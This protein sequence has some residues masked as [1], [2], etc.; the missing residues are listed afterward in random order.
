MDAHEEF[1]IADPHSLAK[2]CARLAQTTQLGFD[3][4]FVGEDTY[5]PSLCLIQVSTPDALYLID[6]LSAGPLDA[7][8]Q[9][10]VEPTRTVIVHAGREET[11]QCQRLSGKTPTNWFDLQIAAGLVGHNYPMGHASLVYQVLGRQLDKHDTLTEWRHRPLS[12]SQIQYAFD[13]VRYLLPLWQTLDGHLAKLGRRDWA[14]DEFARFIAQAVPTPSPLSPL[15]QGEGKGVRGA[16]EKWRKLKGV[17]VLDRKRLALLREMFNAR[18][19]IA[20]Q[21]NRPPRVLVR[22][23]LLVEVARRNPK[24]ADEIQV[25]RGMARRFVQPLWEAI[26]RARQLPSSEMPEPLEREQ[27]RPQVALIVG[28]LSAV[29]NDFCVREKLAVGLTFTMSDLRELVRAKMQNENVPA[30]N[31]LMTGWRRDFVLPVILDVLEGRRRVR[32]ANVQADSPFAL[33]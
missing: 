33:E 3:T 4:E 21:M 7:F 29:L 26:E 2:C 1:V 5:E 20:A 27:D 18:E 14:R 8:W 22:D 24:S 15:P 32:I 13:D 19:A 25:M 16:A 23:D 12:A 11:R 30:T 9:L 10:L 28:L 17:G 31:L 6:P